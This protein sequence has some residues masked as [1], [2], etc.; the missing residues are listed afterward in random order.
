[1]DL[2]AQA[3]NLYL[4]PEYDC[5]RQASAKCMVNEMN[6]RLADRD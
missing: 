4:I 3:I 1:M 6:C 2:P 5:K